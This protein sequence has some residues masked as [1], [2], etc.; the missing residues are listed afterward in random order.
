MMNKTVR[1]VVTLLLLAAL[2]LPVVAAAEIQAVILEDLDL[3]LILPADWSEVEGYDRIIF[4]SP[5]DIGILAVNTGDTLVT[6]GFFDDFSEETVH[7]W[8]RR[9]NEGYEITAFDQLFFSKVYVQGKLYAI[10]D[11]GITIG[12][13]NIV[14]LYYVFTAEDGTLAALSCSVLW[15]DYGETVIDCFY[16]NVWYNTPEEIMDM[17]LEDGE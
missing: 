1:K 13:K 10:S 16:D 2:C 14:C 5:G 11:G 8:I 4:A 6:R 12:D 3:M 17:L 7:D 15:C 9:E